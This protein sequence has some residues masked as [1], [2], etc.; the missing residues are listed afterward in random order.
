MLDALN[1]ENIRRCG[2]ASCTEDALTLCRKC[3]RWFC[4][5]HAS[6]L[7]PTKYCQDCLLVSDADFETAPILDAEGVRHQGKVIRPV[8]VFFSQNG[9]LI[10]EMTDEELR[11]Y[12]KYYQQAV[13]DCE[14]SLDLARIKLGNSL[15]EAGGREIAK[16]KRDTGE[17]VF[18]QPRKAQATPK[19]RASDVAKTPQSEA[20]LADFILKHL[21]PDQLKAFMAKTKKGG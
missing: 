9:K 6:D 20:A 13:H 2:F 4:L 12:I 14:R 15:F 10:H 1:Q 18:I 8:G 3:G 17:V 19:R 16:V 5:E 21:T 11:D 7:E